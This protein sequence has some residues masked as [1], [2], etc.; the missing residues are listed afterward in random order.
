MIQESEKIPIPSL[1]NNDDLIFGISLPIMQI[2]EFE[3]DRESYESWQRFIFLEKCKELG[4]NR[5]VFFL[6]Q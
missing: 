6:N 1:C 3:V 4:K 5:H 2:L